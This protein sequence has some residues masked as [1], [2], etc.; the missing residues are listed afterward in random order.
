MKEEKQNFEEA[1]K[2]LEVIA[3]E[4]ENGDLSLDESVAKF[5]QGMKLSKKCS[6]LLEDAEKRITILLKDEDNNVKEENFIQEEE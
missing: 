4:L 1:I 5:E 2:E 6:D 3:L